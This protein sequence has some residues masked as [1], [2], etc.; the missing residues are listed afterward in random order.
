[1]LVY[2]GGRRHVIY[3]TSSFTRPDLRRLQSP[4]AASI[5]SSVLRRVSAGLRNKAL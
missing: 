1:V 4:V 2:G 3:V 5:G